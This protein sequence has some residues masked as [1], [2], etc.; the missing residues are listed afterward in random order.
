LAS[1]AQ[2]RHFTPGEVGVFDITLA[3][4]VE[5]LDDAVTR[6]AEI[7]QELSLDGPTHAELERVRAMM[8]MQR[9][10]IFES[11]DS[12]ATALCEAEALGSYKLVDE[13]HERLMAVTAEDVKDVTARY[14]NADRSAGVFYLPDGESN[15]FDG[16]AW[17]LRA[18]AASRTRHP[19]TIAF[20]RASSAA[21]DSVIRTAQFDGDITCC[22]YPGIDA[23]AKSKRGCGLVSLGLDVPGLP[24]KET[25]SNAGICSGIAFEG[26][27]VE[28]RDLTASGQVHG[29]W[30]WW[31]DRRGV[32][33]R[34]RVV[35]W[36]D[37]GQQRCR[38][39]GMGYHGAT[40]ESPRGGG[41][42]PFGGSRANLGFPGNR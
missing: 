3:A 16:N 14:L 11:M 32:G 40:G 31:H 20:S 34:G 37:C 17:P 8:V 9:A 10:R 42:G 33:S 6:S 4:D 28:R 35:G 2:A 18:T 38:W 41:I 27:A 19:A 30:G 15:R 25:L 5:R 29:T 36:G 24:S 1:S 22:N 7:V 39:F 13:E 12:R 23:L 26:D 21:A